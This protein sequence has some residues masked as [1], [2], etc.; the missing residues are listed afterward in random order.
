[1]V[2]FKVQHTQ[3]LLLR[4]MYQVES[5]TV[6]GGGMTFKRMEKHMISDSHY[7]AVVT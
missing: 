2:L 1:M 5:G 6:F 7:I 4:R 3:E